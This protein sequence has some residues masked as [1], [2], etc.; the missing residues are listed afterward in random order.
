METWD[1]DFLLHESRL[2]LPG[3]ATAGLALALIQ[4]GG[5]DRHYFRVSATGVHDGPP[6]AILMVYTDRRADNLS[7][8]AATEVIGLTGARTPEI[9]H[10]DANN[11]LAWMED[12]GREDLWEW[13]GDDRLRLPLY[14]SALRQVACLHRFKWDDIPEALKQQMQ[15]SFDE[16]LYAW[17]QDYFFNEFAMRFS[18]AG[19]E[20]LS[21]IRAMDEY[22]ALRRTLASLPKSPVHRDFQSQN[23]IVRDGHAW[24][25]DY[26]G[27]RPGRPEYDLASLLYDPYVS[28]TPAERTEL[29]DYYFALRREDGGECRE[30]W[31][32]MCACQRLM[33]ALGAYGKLGAGDGK[34]AFLHHIT[35][36]VANLRSVVRDSGLLPS[37]EEVLELRP[38]ALTE[39]GLTDPA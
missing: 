23:V 37:L 30:Q 32:A 29:R 13:R 15:P 39:A 2:R 10:H 21:E 25:I 17:E 8:F 31:L 27:L 12:L 3:W 6:S 1:D 22:A 20:R 36:A 11:K 26:Q 16:K 38:G 35:P 7:F 9:Y 19:S 24:M 4:K 34:T 28:L 14:R 18:A 33:Q 5:S